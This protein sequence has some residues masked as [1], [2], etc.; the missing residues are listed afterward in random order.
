M[1]VRAPQHAGNSE[2]PARAQRASGRDGRRVVL[3][4]TDFQHERAVGAEEA[5]DVPALG[6]VGEGPDR[7]GPEVGTAGQEVAE[8][9]RAGVRLEQVAE[10]AELGVV[11]E[12]RD[13]DGLA[14]EGDPPLPVSRRLALRRV[15]A[16]PALAPLGHGVEVERAAQRPGIRWLGRALAAC[17]PVADEAFAAR[18]V[19]DVADV[20]G[21]DAE[22]RPCRAERGDEA[23]GV[24]HGAQP[25]QSGVPADEIGVGQGHHQ[26]SVTTPGRRREP[27]LT[28]SSH[29]PPHFHSYRNAAIGSRRAAFRAG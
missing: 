17:E 16:L 28:R 23:G 19:V 14:W 6:L 20:D 2:Q 29:S 21:F 11:G 1:L 3:G 13:R 5:A 7:A 27:V 18:L 15:L 25:R 22:L 10:R 24:E 9:A 26:A 4:S 12:E 8:Q